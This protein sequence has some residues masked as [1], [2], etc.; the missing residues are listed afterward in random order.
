MV[1]AERKSGRMAFAP[2]SRAGPNALEQAP[3]PVRVQLR[4]AARQ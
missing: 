1:E 2:L 4:R 3:G